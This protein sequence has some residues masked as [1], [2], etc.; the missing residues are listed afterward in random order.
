MFR[1]NCLDA[2]AHVP[3]PNLSLRMLERSPS[4]PSGLWSI[5]FHHLSWS[6]K[7]GGGGGGGG[8]GCGGWGGVAEVTAILLAAYFA[9]NS[10]FPK[11]KHTHKMLTQ[12]NT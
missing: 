10:L 5:D 12:T 7:K 8:D 6:L 11:V 9:K 4:P 2:L 3:C 1:C